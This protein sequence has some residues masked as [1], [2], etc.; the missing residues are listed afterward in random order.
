MAKDSSAVETVLPPGVFITTTPRCVAAS[1]STLST[2]TPA[3]PTTRNLRRRLDD[4]ARHFGL[5]AHDHRHDVFDHR[6]QLRLGQPLGQHHDLEF[7]P[8][9]QQGNAL[10]RHGVTH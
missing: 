5:G 4:F 10:G 1:T 3:R 8:L 7:G 9:L 6:Q 2:P